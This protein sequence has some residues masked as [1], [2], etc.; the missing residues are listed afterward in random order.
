MVEATGYNA[1]DFAIFGAGY[2]V[3]QFEGKTLDLIVSFNDSGQPPLGSAMDVMTIGDQRPR[4]IIPPMAV[5]SGTLNFSMYALR[6]Q[7]LFSSIF[8]GKFKGAKDLV[9]LFNQQIK[10]GVMQ[11]VWVTIDEDGAPTKALGYQGVI[12]TNVTNGIQVNNTGA[13]QATYNF[14]AKYTRA[15]EL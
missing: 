7:G 10:L 14:T 2:G 1:K 5:S 8:N 3:L 4:A 15:S 11:L 9:D 6:A 12:I 13:R